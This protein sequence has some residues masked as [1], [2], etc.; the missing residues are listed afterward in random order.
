MQLLDCERR[1]F[2]FPPFLPQ[3]IFYNFKRTGGTLMWRVIDR[4]FPPSISLRREGT[5]EWL[6]YLSPT[7]NL[8]P[9]TLSPSVPISAVIYGF[10][11]SG[12]ALQSL[13]LLHRRMAHLV[14]P[15]CPPT[16]SAEARAFPASLVLVYNAQRGS[17]RVFAW[18]E[19]S[20]SGKGK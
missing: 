9:S 7:L 1:G 15:P 5:N 2:H 3:F 8:P 4:K 19:C 16:S 12:C 20:Q 17:S 18:K 10:F 13:R 14:P 6:N 11:P